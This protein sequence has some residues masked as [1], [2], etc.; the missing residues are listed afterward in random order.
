MSYLGMDV[1]KCQ[2]KPVSVAGLTSPGAFV[3]SS[4]V[5]QG[6]L[7]HAALLPAIADESALDAQH[8]RQRLPLNAHLK[9][10]LRFQPTLPLHMLHSDCCE[11]L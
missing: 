1:P 4:I 7:L 10:A 3:L 6:Q 9:G 11:C 5:L 2:D 8:R